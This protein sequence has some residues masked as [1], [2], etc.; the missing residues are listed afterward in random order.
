MREY[1]IVIPSIRRLQLSFLEVGSLLFHKQ[2]TL[3]E[4]RSPLEA[5]PMRINSRK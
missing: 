4:E 1:A 2:Q 3:L 5:W